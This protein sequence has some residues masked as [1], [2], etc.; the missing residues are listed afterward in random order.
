MSLPTKELLLKVQKINHRRSFKIPNGKQYQYKDIVFLDRFHCLKISENTEKSQ[1]AILFLYGGGM[2]LSPHGSNIKFAARVGKR[3]KSDIWFPYY[4]L[5]IENSIDML[6][7]MLFEVYKRMLKEY[8]AE[9]I[10]FLGFS[11]GAA[12]SIG[13]CQYNHEQNNFLPI[14]KQIIACSPGCVPLSEEETAKMRNL[15]EKDIIV[16][17]GFMLHMKDIMTHGKDIP[18]YM[19]SG[20]RGD[21][22]DMPEIHFYYGTDEV[23]YAEADYFER[24]CKKHGVTYHMHIGNGMCHCY[25]MMP[26]IP[27]AKRALNEIIQILL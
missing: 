27:E 6:Y 21:F 17:A 22:T 23:L 15:S 26:F 25:P 19:L 7:N 12:L 1:K 8:D 24:A 16:D 5:C 9:N 11:S 2:I 13:L 14:P 10:S 20:A 4:P 3:S 18:K